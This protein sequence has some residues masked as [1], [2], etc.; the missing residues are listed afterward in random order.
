VTCCLSPTNSFPEISEH[1]ATSHVI[2]KTIFDYVYVA[3]SLF[4]FQP[5]HRSRSLKVT[6][7]E[8]GVSRIL[9]WSLR[10]LDFRAFCAQKLSAE[11][12]KIE[13]PKAPMG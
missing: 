12:A 7:Y 2:L 4:N 10:S 11:G 3:D 13:A 6:D 5:L 9:H 8:G 1:I